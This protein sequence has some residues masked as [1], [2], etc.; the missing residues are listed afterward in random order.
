MANYGW[1]DRK[2]GRRLP[3]GVSGGV[4]TEL[5]R[6]G[7]GATQGG[8][9]DAMAREERSTPA[10]R[11]ATTRPAT[12]VDEALD[13]FDWRKAIDKPAAKQ[14]SSKYDQQLSQLD[15]LLNNVLHGDQESG[16]HASPITS[17][18]VMSAAQS[19]HTP[20]G[21]GRY[22]SIQ[23][24]YQSPDNQAALGKL[25]GEAAYLTRISNAA[26]YPQA[27]DQYQTD[28]TTGNANT[29]VPG[30]SVQDAIQKL[31]PG[32]GWDYNASTGQWSAPGQARSV[33]RTE[34]GGQNRAGEFNY[35]RSIPVGSPTG[36]VPPVSNPIPNGVDWPELPKTQGLL[37]P[38]KV[39]GNDRNDLNDMLN[40]S[41]ETQFVA[42]KPV[43]TPT[44]TPPPVKKE[45]ESYV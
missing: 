16:S 41:P 34:A 4:Y 11:P 26:N 13:T 1:V 40:S 21:A 19:S 31:S 5:T 12:T 36:D 22:S 8:F 27:P 35:Q 28:P 17:L 14:G 18:D 38:V 7:R 33:V 25:G 24:L 2:T 29:N 3:I 32:A 37:E 42:P 15:D 43:P 45:N 39:A 30:G 44:P 9:E 23:S 10:T 20:D 6:D